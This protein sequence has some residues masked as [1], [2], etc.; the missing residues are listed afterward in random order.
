V[1]PGQDQLKRDGRC[2]IV[3]SEG[4]ENGDIGELRIVLDIRSLALQNYV[5]QK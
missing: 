5:S 1:R 3:V 2:V 4:F